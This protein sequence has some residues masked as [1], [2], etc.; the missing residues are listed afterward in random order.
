MSP[1]CAFIYDLLIRIACRWYLT[2]PCENMMSMS[3]I[4]HAILNTN[5]SSDNT[6][7]FPQYIWSSDE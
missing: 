5:K 2:I 4:N 1:I 6:K 7:Y 3:K